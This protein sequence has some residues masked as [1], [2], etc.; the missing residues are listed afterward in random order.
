[1]DLLRRLYWE[2]AVVMLVT[3]IMG[4]HTYRWDAKLD[5]FDAEKP[6][7]IAEWTFEGGPRDFGVG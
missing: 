6:T 2:H 7:P 3:E 4:D 1:M 5:T